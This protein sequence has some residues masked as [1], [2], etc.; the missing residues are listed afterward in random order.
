MTLATQKGETTQTS[1]NIL[2]FYPLQSIHCVKDLLMINPGGGGGGG[3]HL[4]I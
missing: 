1:I 4:G 2:T 3:G